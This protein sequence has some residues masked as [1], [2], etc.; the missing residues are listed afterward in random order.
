MRFL[1]MKSR[2]DRGPH[3]VVDFLINSPLFGLIG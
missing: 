1:R 2:R 3:K